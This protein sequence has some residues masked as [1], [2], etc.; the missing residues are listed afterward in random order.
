MVCENTRGGYVGL[1][2]G[3]VSWYVGTCLTFMKNY[4]KMHKLSCHC[5]CY[6]K[7]KR[8]HYQLLP[9]WG[10]VL[11][12]SWTSLSTLHFVERDYKC[13]Y[14]NPDKISQKGWG[15]FV[16]R[17]MGSNKLKCKYRCP[18]AIIILINVLLFLKSQYKYLFDF[19]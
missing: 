4:K 5:K 18:I 3:Y 17:S 8:G 2:L 9:L 10:H 11:Q 16:K 7:I 15:V 6:I 14:V 19:A 13:L 1:R 12:I